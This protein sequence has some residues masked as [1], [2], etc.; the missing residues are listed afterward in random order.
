VQSKGFKPKTRGRKLICDVYWQGAFKQKGVKQR[1]LVIP[2]K[3]LLEDRIYAPLVK[4]SLLYM[5]HEVS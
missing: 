3:F 1:L 2:A 4:N 5:E